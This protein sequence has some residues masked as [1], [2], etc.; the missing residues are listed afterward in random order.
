VRREGNLG[1]PAASV[2]PPSPFPFLAPAVV[3]MWRARR[4]LVDGGV[5]WWSA[6]GQPGR[7]EASAA[8]ASPFPSSLLTMTTARWL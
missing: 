3:V 7:P 4:L 5:E 6:E 1:G 2:A 8:P